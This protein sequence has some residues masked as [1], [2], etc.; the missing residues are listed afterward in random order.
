MKRRF[1]TFRKIIMY[2]FRQNKFCLIKPQTIV[3]HL[4]T[5]SIAGTI[6]KFSLKRFSIL[7]FVITNVKRDFDTKAIIFFCFR[8][9]MEWNWSKTNDC[10]CWYMGF[11]LSAGFVLG[12][13]TRY[14]TFLIET[15]LFSKFLLV[16]TWYSY[17]FEMWKSVAHP[18]TIYIFL[19]CKLHFLL[20]L[21]SHFSRDQHSQ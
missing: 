3:Q 6:L 10:F 20:Y 9:K 16:V 1:K 4:Y 7:L 11:C 14:Y 18:N 19:L 15:K 21:L 13:Y 2:L 17:N 8:M 12:C 5:I